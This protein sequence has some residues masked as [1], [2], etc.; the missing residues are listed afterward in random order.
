MGC[1]RG[2]R[3][4]SLSGRVPCSGSFKGVVP[5]PHFVP[6]ERNP[7]VAAMEVKI[8]LS[9]KIVATA[10]NRYHTCERGEQ[11]SAMC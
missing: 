4:K 6:V 11:E 8:G 7:P 3:R 10:R 9:G 1:P 5:F 2:P